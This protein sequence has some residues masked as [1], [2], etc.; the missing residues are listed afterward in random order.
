MEDLKTQIQRSKQ[1]KPNNSTEMS[2]GN[3]GGASAVNEDQLLQMYYSSAG[4]MNQTAQFDSA[5][6]APPLPSTSVFQKV[7]AN[8]PP[9]PA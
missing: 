2:L 3:V 4:A 8:F 7:E 1:A 5:L 9:V 6:V